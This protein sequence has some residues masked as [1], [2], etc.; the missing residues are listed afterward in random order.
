M[1]EPIIELQNVSF[2]AQNLQIVQNISHKFEEGKTTALVGPSGGGK[3]T[4]L[5]LAA[6]LLLP[7]EGAVTFRGKDVSVMSRAQNLAFRK[8]SAVVFQD[9]A[10]WANQS[11]R[12]ILELPLKIHFPHMTYEART[13]RITQVLSET[14]YK[15]E[16]DIRPSQ[17]SMGEQKLIAFARAMLCDPSLIFLDEWTESLDESAGNRL[18]K[19]IKQKKKE[20]KTIIFVSHDFRVIED[21]AD[22]ICMIIDGRLSLVITGEQIAKD[23]SLALIIEKG[24]AL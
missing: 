21:L 16:L 15:K 3:S 14:G 12:Q 5:K 11:L 17:L 19:I 23:D 18:V 7:T 2:S 20:E 22:Y 10:L 1:T 6:G 4:V 24:I 9:S 8:A 13:A